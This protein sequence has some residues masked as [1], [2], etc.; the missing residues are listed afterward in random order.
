VATEPPEGW[1]ERMARRAE[2]DAAFMAS[3]LAAFRR[4]QRLDDRALAEFLRCP[5]EMLPHL[6]LCRRPDPA[7]P[8]FQADVTQIATHARADPDRLVRLLRRVDLAVAFGTS[9]AADHLAAARDREEEADT[10]RDTER[11]D[12]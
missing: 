12:G 8:R 4:L 3:A 7:S 1:H 9:T 10:Q 5:V 11:D 6:A 2:Q